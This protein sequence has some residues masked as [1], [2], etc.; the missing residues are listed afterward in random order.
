VDFSDHR[1][2]WKH[3]YPAAMVTGTSF[4]RNPRHHTPAD[5]PETLDYARMAEVVKGVHCAVQS[6]ARR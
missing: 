3:H 1:S 2:F 5:R 6:V 4:Y